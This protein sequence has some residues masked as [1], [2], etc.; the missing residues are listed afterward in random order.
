MS[1]GVVEQVQDTIVVQVI[2]DDKPFCVGR[3][4]HIINCPLA[5]TDV[6][7]YQ[8]CADVP[9]GDCRKIVG[10][11]CGLRRRVSGYR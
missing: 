7:A 2:F 6:P 9:R 3:M 1:R 10:G 4:G 8:P 11:V 5:G